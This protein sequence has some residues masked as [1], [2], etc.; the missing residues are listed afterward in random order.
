MIRIG[1]QIDEALRLPVHEAE[2]HVAQNLR[3]FAG[4][5]HEGLA[6]NADFKPAGVASETRVAQG[7]APAKCRSPE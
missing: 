5:R 2:C 4:G 3:A 6:H 1:Q 7:A